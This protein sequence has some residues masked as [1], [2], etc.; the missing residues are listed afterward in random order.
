[1]VVPQL[2]MVITLLTVI[3][4]FIKTAINILVDIFKTL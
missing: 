3:V 1:M 4:Y 2:F